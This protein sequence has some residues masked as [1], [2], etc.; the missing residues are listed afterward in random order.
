MSASTPAYQYDEFRGLAHDFHDP[1]Q[2]A[3]YDARQHT[4]IERERRLVSELGI[5]ADSVVI[6]YGA[7]TG[8]FTA[9]SAAVARHVHSVDISQAMLAYSRRRAEADGLRNISYHHAGFLTY[10]HRG[11][12]ADF[13]V[14]KFAFHHLPDYWKVAA[15]HRLAGFLKPGGLLHLQDV[16]FSFA[17]GEAAHSIEHWITHQTAGGGGFS[18]ADFEA[19]VRDEHST[20]DWILDDM[21]AR[22][23]FLVTKKEIWSPTYAAYHARR[24]GPVLAAA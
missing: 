19:H 16:V 1:A 7:G 11:E 23:G 2:V 21:L 5:G 18:R 4:Q 17:P 22:T 14:T 12:P 15:L 3:A 6:E 8:A 10:E 20:F 13:I 9:A 24:R